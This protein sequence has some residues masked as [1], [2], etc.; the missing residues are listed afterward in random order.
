[1]RI[2]LN[3]EAMQCVEG[4]SAAQLLAQL[5]LDRP[6]TALAVNQTILPR[7]QWPDYTLQEGDSLL[8][9]QVIAGG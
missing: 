2:E 7:S 3:D 6:G 4:V 9:F 8:L 1:M 5:K